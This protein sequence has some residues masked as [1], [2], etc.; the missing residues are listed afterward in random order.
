MKVIHTAD[1]HL[2]KILNG[3]S[4]LEDQSY[5]LDAFVDAV[6]AEQPDVVVVAGG[7]YYTNY[8]SKKTEQFL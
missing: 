5:I 4:F 8:P 7:F 3:K 2:G 1:W 6:E